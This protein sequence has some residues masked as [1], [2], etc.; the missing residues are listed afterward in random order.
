L[1][2]VYILIKLLCLGSWKLPF[3]GKKEGQKAELAS[4]LRSGLRLAQPGGPTTRVS[5]LPFYL[6]M[7]DDPAS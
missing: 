1:S 2:I 5:I 3:S 6:K 4:D 7:E